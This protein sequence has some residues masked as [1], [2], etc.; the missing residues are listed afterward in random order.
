MTSISQT[1][2]SP[3]AVIKT[4]CPTTLWWHWNLEMWGVMFE[5]RFHQLV[6]TDGNFKSVTSYFLHKHSWENT[7]SQFSV[8][9]WREGKIQD[10]IPWHAIPYIR[11][12]LCSAALCLNLFRPEWPPWDVSNIAQGHD[13]QVLVNFIPLRLCDKYSVFILLLDSIITALFN[14]VEESDFLTAVLQYKKVNNEWLHVLHDKFD[15]VGDSTKSHVYL[16]VTAGTELHTCDAF[17]RTRIF[18]KTG[19]VT[20][21]K[22][23]LIISLYC[24]KYFKWPE[25]IKCILHNKYKLCG[26]NPR[27]PL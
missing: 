24:Y 3:S 1:C 8:V 9:F 14:Y 5:E 19:R 26:G 20:A 16:F 12:G 2:S 11:E 22:S 15:I 7:L 23:F 18:Q 25:S 4:Y 21:Y 17:C 27:L 10:G 13:V 6:A